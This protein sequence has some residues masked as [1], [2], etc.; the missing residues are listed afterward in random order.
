MCQIGGGLQLQTNKDNNFGILGRNKYFDNLTSDS[1]S[2][3]ENMSKN[4]PPKFFPWGIRLATI[5]D[6]LSGSST[7]L[8]TPWQAPNAKGDLKI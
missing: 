4:T 7:D 6:I 2:G 3:Y 5:L 8:G 1:N